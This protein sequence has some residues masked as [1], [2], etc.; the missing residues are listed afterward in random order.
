MGKKCIF[1]VFNPFIAYRLY[2]RVKN[3]KNA[4]FARIL[5]LPEPKTGILLLKIKSFYTK[6][7]VRFPLSP[8]ISMERGKNPC[9]N[10]IGRF[11]LELG[12]STVSAPWDWSGQKGASR[13]VLF[14]DNLTGT[15]KGSIKVERW[16]SFTITQQKS[17][18]IGTPVVI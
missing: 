14:R 5:G 1:L 12:F 16:R 7:G 10:W 13:V 2:K 3:Q 8:N 6:S 9:G 11:D 15:E 18:F 4:L 17:I